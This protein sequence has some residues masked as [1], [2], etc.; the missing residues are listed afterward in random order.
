MGLVLGVRS[1]GRCRRKRDSGASKEASSCVDPASIPGRLGGGCLPRLA[2]P[3]FL[4]I[5]VTPLAYSISAGIFAGIASYFV[6]GAVLAAAEAADRAGDR[7]GGAL[8]GVGAPAPRRDDVALRG[9]F[10]SGV[11]VCV[12]V[13]PWGAKLQGDVL[14][15]P[16]IMLEGRFWRWSSSAALLGL[17]T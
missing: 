2:L 16:D 12:C 4:T 1:F 8:R 6:L 13:F 15:T 10:G 11:G 3:A 5:C 17:V 9:K 14:K 7:L